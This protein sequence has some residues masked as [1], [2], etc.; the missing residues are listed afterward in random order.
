MFSALVTR[1]STSVL[2]LCL[3]ICPSCACL[4]NIINITNTHYNMFWKTVLPA[5]VPAVILQLISLQL[6]H[7]PFSNW[8][9]RMYHSSHLPCCIQM[10]CFFWPALMLFL[11]TWILSFN[12]KTY[13]ILFHFCLTSDQ[14]SRNSCL[15]KRGLTTYRDECGA[16]I[17]VPRQ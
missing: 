7:K 17:E 6:M 8:H 13:W 1:F 16:N 4:V 14:M 11:L 2:C 5:T 9:N 12:S 10:F 15:N 3:C